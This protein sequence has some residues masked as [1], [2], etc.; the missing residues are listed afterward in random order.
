MKRSVMKAAALLMSLLLML[1]AAACGGK[2]E[3]TT[4]AA[5]TAASGTFPAPSTTAAPS[6][7]ASTEAATT[8]EETTPAEPAPEEVPVTNLHPVTTGYYVSSSE[9]ETYRL[10]AAVTYSCYNLNEEEA[11]AWPALASALADYSKDEEDLTLADFEDLVEL[12]KT[13]PDEDGYYEHTTNTVLRADTRMFSV[14]SELSAN[15]GETPYTVYYSNN[16]DTADGRHLLLTDVI[17][18]TEGFFDLIDEK[19]KISCDEVYSSLG[20]VPSILR[21]LDLTDPYDICWAS[22]PVGIYVIFNEG[23]FSDAVQCDI[24]ELVTF[25]EA[26]QLFNER[27]TQVPDSYVIPMTEGLPLYLPLGAGGEPVLLEIY[28][29][30]DEYDTYVVWHLSI[31]DKIYDIA[32]WTYSQSSYI[33]CRDGKYYM[34]VFESSDND[35]STLRVI[36]LADPVIKERVDMSGTSLGGGLDYGWEEGEDGVYTNWASSTVFTDPESFILGDRIDYLATTTGGKEFR[37]GA[38]G[39]P[40]GLAEYFDIEV[41]YAYKVIADVACQTVDETGKVTGDYTLAPGTFITLVRSDGD[42][43]MDVRIIDEKNVTAE[44]D[45]DWHYYTI[46]DGYTDDSSQLYRLTKDADEWAKYNGIEEYELFEGMTYA[47]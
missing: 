16:Y 37:M 24:K 6:E 15:M 33:L 27:Y 7:P 14:L 34:Y 13:S 46:N 26:P 12:Y 20:D 18:D 22:C 36:D 4:A 2:T 43:I 11:A 23:T 17:A 3:D 45:G 19:L 44:G 39:M 47:G 9:D 1:G 21:S 29:E 30:P 31:G 40:E 42:R 35:Y 5:T 28:G 25:A 41:G 32:D 10:R 8:P 38:D